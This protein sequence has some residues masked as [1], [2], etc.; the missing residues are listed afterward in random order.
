VSCLLRIQFC[1]FSGFHVFRYPPPPLHGN[2]KFLRSD[3]L[4]EKFVWGMIEASGGGNFVTVG[5]SGALTVDF[6][7]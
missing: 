5:H 1:S 7:K 3:H 4:W 2:S 6:L